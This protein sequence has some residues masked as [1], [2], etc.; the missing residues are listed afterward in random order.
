MSSI[1][2]KNIIFHAFC[3]KEGTACKLPQ[4]IW[5]EATNAKS[6]D[7]HT[8]ERQGQFGTGTHC[9]KN[10]HENCK[11]N[12]DDTLYLKWSLKHSR[13]SRHVFQANGGSKRVELPPNHFSTSTAKPTY[14]SKVVYQSQIHRVLFQDAIRYPVLHMHSYNEGSPWTTC[15]VSAARLII[16]FPTLLSPFKCHYGPA[17]LSSMKYVHTKQLKNSNQLTIMCR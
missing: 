10:A 5:K 11:I 17:T 13:F 12:S 14:N 7:W 4:L 2:N 15:G 6:G 16:D 1:K 8:Q 3:R 9:S